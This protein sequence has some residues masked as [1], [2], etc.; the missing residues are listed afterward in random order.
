[1]E[2]R[3]D[4]LHMHAVRLAKKALLSYPNPRDWGKDIFL[5]AHHLKPQLGEYFAQTE[6][7]APIPQVSWGKK[8]VGKNHH[9]CPKSAYGM[10]WY[11]EKSSG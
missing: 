8:V 11:E 3:R 10:I 7:T 9:V 4:S 6:R 1:M 2:T 5:P